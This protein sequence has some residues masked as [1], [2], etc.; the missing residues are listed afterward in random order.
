MIWI[1]PRTVVLGLRMRMER[2]FRT[3]SMMIGDPRLHFRHAAAE[4]TVL[5]REN[6]LQSNNAVSK[7]IMIVILLLTV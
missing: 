2:S 6:M 4:L 3:V 7:V 1:P 5:K